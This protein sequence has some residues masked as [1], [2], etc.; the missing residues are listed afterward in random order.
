MSFQY[1]HSVHSNY[2]IIFSNFILVC[3]MPHFPSIFLLFYFFIF[4][5]CHFFDSLFL[6]LSLPTHKTN[7][8]FLSFLSFSFLF[9]YFIS[10]YFILKST[11]TNFEFS[12]ELIRT[13]LS[14]SLS[15]YLS[16]YLSI[17]RFYTQFNLPYKLISLSSAFLLLIYS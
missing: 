6:A 17:S 1:F 16:I 3:S 8:T 12:S 5:I 14:L 11:T 10:F 13:P 7:T 9:F 2:F 4:L 15:I